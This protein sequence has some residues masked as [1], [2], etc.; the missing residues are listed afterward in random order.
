MR[1]LLLFLFGAA[2]PLA[3]YLGVFYPDRSQTLKAAEK[4]QA[5]LRDM[6]VAPVEALVHASGQK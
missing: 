1:G 6:I 4:P 2:I 5:V 3:T